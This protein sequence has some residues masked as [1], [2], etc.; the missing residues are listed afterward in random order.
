MSPRPF[1]LRKISN[2]PVISGFKPYGFEKN[3]IKPGSVFL[4]LEEYEAL[5]LC[6][7]E[8]LNHHQAAI[9][10][11]ISR[12]TLTRIYSKARIKIAEA[13][14]Q[15]KQIII[16][17]GK[18]YFDSEWY[19]CRSCGCY[20][21]NPEKQDKIKECPLCRSSDF[22]NYEPGPEENDEN[23]TRCRDTCVCASCGFEKPHRFG[24]PCKEEKCPVCGTSLSRKG[25]LH[26]RNF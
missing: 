3:A 12:P 4:H 21:N 5:R 26:Q 1:R 20:F 6:D 13:L 8:M 23:L 24:C 18:I 11:A 22:L 2:P 14:V 25:T 19:S 17:G 10:M 16:Q 7:Y 9:L 15:G